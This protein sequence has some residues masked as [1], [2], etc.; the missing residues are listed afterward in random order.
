MNDKSNPLSVP[1]AC[2]GW[3]VRTLPTVVVMAALAG[4]AFWGHHTGWNFGAENPRAMIGSA[5]DASD[6]IRVLDDPETPDYGWCSRHGVY[7]CPLEHPDV[8]QTVRRPTITKADFE[9]VRRALAVRPRAEN[10]P[11]YRG[12]RRRLHFASEEAVTKTGIDS[13]PV[14]S[15]AVTEVV[16]A[17]GEISFDPT[18]MA[19]LTA[20]AS[21]TAR[22]VAKT[23]GDPVRAGEVLAL[24]DAKEVGM[25]K[26]QFLGP[27]VQMRRKRKYLASLRAAGRSVS[28]RQIQ[29]A[30]ASLRDAEARLLGAE[31]TLFNLGLPVRAADNADAP[32]E[33]LHRRLQFL[34]VPE[35][36][37]QHLD[38]ASRTGNLL[39]VR[40]PFDGVV[41][42]CDVINGELLD[43]SKVLFVIVDPRRVW[44]TLHVG[45]DDMG[46]VAR[47]QTVKFRPDGLK[48]EFTGKLT[49]IGTGSDEKTRTV[50]VRAELS[51]KEG[52]LRAST[53]G[54][55]RIVL[56][57]EPD[58]LVVPAEAVQL[59]GGC[60]IVF[61]RHKDYL[62]PVGPKD[63]FVR[64]VRT[65][66]RQGA[67]T[68]IIAGVL[69]EESVV[70]KGSGRLLR[71]LKKS[72]VADEN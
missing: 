1:R 50:P 33:E 24:V 61:V 38:Q 49:W 47:G 18:R 40:A 43:T 3:L 5:K 27:L 31:Q 23:I 7:N 15:E 4:L 67:N 12:H 45:L 17:S 16:T 36:L 51:N 42:K 6:W 44:L 46:C 63:F 2:L 64:T 14:L 59:D 48:E 52:R 28:R 70:T 19:R 55:G 58:A 65:G 37:V 39:P 56:R 29:E 13:F 62:E 11:V 57:E 21:G 71:E 20:R 54:V 8:A 25:A 22:Y 30:E 72:A 10:D 35:T 26:S 66:A 9:R 41:L 53:F 69:K 32:I 34:G 68:E 60:Q